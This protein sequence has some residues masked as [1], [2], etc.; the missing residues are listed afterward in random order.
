MLLRI[1]KILWWIILPWVLLFRYF[2]DKKSGHGFCYLFERLGLSRTTRP[3]DIILHAVSLGEVR[4]MTPL[5]FEIQKQLPDLSILITT[6][7]LT[8]RKQIEQ[9]FGNTVSVAFLPHD[10]GFFIHRFLKKVQPKILMIME[11]EIW[12]N[13]LD[14]CQKLNISTFIISACLSDRSQKGYAKIPKT[15]QQLLKNVNILAQTVEDQ[16]RFLAVGARKVSVMGNLKYITVLPDDFNAKTQT[17]LLAKQ[18]YLLWCVAS[19]H[20][21][22]EKI[23]LDEFKKIHKEFPQ[24]KLAIAPRHPERFSS[25]ES[26]IQDHGYRYQKRSDMGFDELSFEHTD[27]WLWNSIG[28]LL[29]LYGV[30]DIITVGGSFVPIGGHNIL[31]PAYLHKVITVGPC[32]DN[33][34]DMVTQFMEYHAIIILEQQDLYAQLTPLIKDPK[35][36]NMMGQNAYLC[37][38][39]NQDS[40]S[41]IMDALHQCVSQEG[42]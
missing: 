2:K 42:Q 20:E 1:Y 10:I 40:L 4:A 27:V 7:T 24:V 41:H 17:L 28:E 8:G 37:I 23:I 22:E 16:N 12:P 33:I 34:Q 38:M 5:V 19:T 30:A 26:L 18:N 3:H 25:V 9:S 32:I 11:T 6:T 14:S 31:E 15:I 13:L 36:R 39:K 35:M 21:G 29:Y